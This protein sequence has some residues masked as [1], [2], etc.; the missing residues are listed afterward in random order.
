MVFEQLTSWLPPKPTSKLAGSKSPNSPSYCTNNEPLM[1]SIGSSQPPGVTSPIA[2]V[3]FLRA[4]AF[5]AVTNR[6]FLDRRGSRLSA[7]ARGP[8]AF[9]ERDRSPEIQRIRIYSRGQR[10]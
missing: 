1:L 5:S 9:R 4:Q 8:D 6:S 3:Q 7:Q 10:P 2:P